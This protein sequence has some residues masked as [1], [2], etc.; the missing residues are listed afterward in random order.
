MI[1]AVNNEHDWENFFPYIFRAFYIFP[2]KTIYF[3]QQSKFTFLHY[4]W[5]RIVSNFYVKCVYINKQTHTHILISAHKNSYPHILNYASIII[6]STFKELY[7]KHVSR[8]YDYNLI[9]SR[10]NWTMLLN[11]LQLYFHLRLCRNCWF[12]SFYN[13]CKQLTTVTFTNY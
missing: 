2:N 6:F 10:D 3:S 7:F 11:Y 9:L 5:W 4:F 13:T 8:I 1:N 12:S